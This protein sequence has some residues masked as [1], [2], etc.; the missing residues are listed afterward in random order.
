MKIISLCYYL[1]SYRQLLASSVDA[2]TLID[3]HNPTPVLIRVC[4]EGL[5][6]FAEV[7]L[8]HGARVR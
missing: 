3:K 4:E 5:Y 8:E 1:Y 2:N 6:Q 7:L